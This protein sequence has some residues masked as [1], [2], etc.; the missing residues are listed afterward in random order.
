MIETS[1]LLSFIAATIALILLPGPNIA[2]IVATGA[3]HGPRAALT[4]VVGTTLAEAVQIALVVAGLGALLTAY[5]WAFSVVKWAGIA[6]LVWLGIS[7]IRAPV[8]QQAEPLHSA[9]F[10]RG[11]ATALANP[12]TMLFHAAF[13]PLFVDASRPVAMQFITLSAVFLA[14]AFVL[15]SVYAIASGQLSRLLRGEGFKR[16][17]NRLSGGAMLLAAGWL[18]LRRSH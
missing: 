7:A 9:L 14:T 15:D 2:V 10:M 3:S 17:V 16:W 12:K 1:V 11:A 8:M 4:V 5:S 6:Y 13:L 18:A